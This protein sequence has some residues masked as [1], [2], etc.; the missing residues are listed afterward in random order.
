MRVKGVFSRP[1]LL[2]LA[3][4]LGLVAA[5]AGTA[6]AQT[7]A[8]LL[9][10]CRDAAKS[11]PQRIDACGRLIEL[12]GDAGM[13]AEA[14]LQLGVL[15]EI[16][17]ALEAAV[18]D[19]TEAIKLDAANPLAFFNR[20]NAHDQLGR[21]DLAI[22]DY[23]QAIKLDRKEPDFFTRRGQTYDGMGRHDL[24]IAD[25]TEAIRLDK[26]SARPL[27][28]RGLSH[29]NMG[30]YRRAIADFDQAIKLSPDDVDLH[31]A[32]GAAHEELGERSAAI[33]DY[34][35]VLEMD[36]DNE[37]AREGLNRLGG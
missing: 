8:E 25:H 19:Y 21:H 20:G 2:P 33:A 29:A 9:D 35:R 26:G 31:V 27:Y 1:R 18:T 12:A 16:G 15:R 24:A 10:A 32:R 7:A 22:A 5:A 28:N 6:G 11:A 3:S 13:R 34:R 30:D 17:G 4:M 37:D 14:H 36:P 23:T